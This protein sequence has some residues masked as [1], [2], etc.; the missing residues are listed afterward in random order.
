L[1][2]FLEKHFIEREI[3]GNIYQINITLKITE[4]MLSLFENCQQKA[5]LGVFYGNITIWSKQWSMQVKKLKD[6]R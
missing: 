4:K 3:E 1:F 5:L 6:M 2:F